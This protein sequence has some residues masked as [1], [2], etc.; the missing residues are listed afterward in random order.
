MKPSN[1][2]ITSRKVLKTRRRLLRRQS[3]PAES[4]L[5]QALRGRRLQGRKFKRQFSVGPYILDFYCVAEKLAVELDGSVHDDPFR[6]ASDA[7][8]TVFLEAH[9]IR[10]MRFENRLVF[11]QLPVVLDAITYHFADE[12]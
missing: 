1:R 11:E 6:Q 5:W 8:R 2:R 12:R 7:E 10:T 4:V 3:T 9:G